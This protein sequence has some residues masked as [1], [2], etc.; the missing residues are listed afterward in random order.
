MN[1]YTV[2]LFATGTR[3]TVDAQDAWTALEQQTSP[4]FTVVRR[5]G[6]QY[7]AMTNKNESF[8]V[9]GEHV[10]STPEAAAAAIRQHYAAMKKPART[11]PPVN[12]PQ[13]CVVYL[14][15]G[16]EKRTA[17]MSRERATQALAVMRA[18]YGERNA[19]VYVD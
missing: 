13:C 19:I 6:G 2:E 10:A 16:K 8:P 17:W 18:K 5:T 3:H 12:S 11:Q 4:C 14:E 9:A 7:A 1:T 15:G